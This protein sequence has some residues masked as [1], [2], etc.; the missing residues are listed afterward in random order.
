MFEE[1]YLKIEAISFKK[2]CGRI[3]NI[4]TLTK[5]VFFMMK[6]YYQRILNCLVIQI[7]Q[8]KVTNLGQNQLVVVV[9]SD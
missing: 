2:G 4:A 3:I 5:P 7:K 1:P 8:K 6:I 9:T